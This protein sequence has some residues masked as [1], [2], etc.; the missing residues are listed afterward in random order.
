M[1][2]LKMIIFDLKIEAE[3]KIW[4]WHDSKGSNNSCKKLAGISTH[5]EKVGCDTVE[6]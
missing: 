5:D 1:T 3:W 2:K 4:L 6:L